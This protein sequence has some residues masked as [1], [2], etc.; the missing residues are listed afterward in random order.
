MAVGT[1]RNSFL[2]NSSRSRGGMRG[3]AVRE[4]DTPL[5]H[6]AGVAG[7]HQDRA[8]AGGEVGEFG[9]VDESPGRWGWRG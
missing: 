7:V 2:E 6:R 3:V 8:R 5:T 9:G 1:G 4:E